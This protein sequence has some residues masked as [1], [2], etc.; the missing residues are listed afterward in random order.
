M[1]RW[2][3]TTDNWPLALIE[4]HVG[5]CETGPCP[6]AGSFAADAGAISGTGPGPGP[7]TSHSTTR[8]RGLS[9]RQGC[10]AMVVASLRGL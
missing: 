8:L 3:S 2:L 7:G 10:M 1:E 4:T 9:A 6:A 5:E